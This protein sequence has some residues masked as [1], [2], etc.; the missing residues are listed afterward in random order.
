MMAVFDAHQ[1]ANG[2]GRVVPAA[3]ASITGHRISA[4]LKKVRARSWLA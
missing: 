3:L 2:P 1:R 4:L